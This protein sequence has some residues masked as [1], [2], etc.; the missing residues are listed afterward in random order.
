MAVLP[1]VH[2]EVLL[3]EESSLVLVPWMSHYHLPPA[4][5]RRLQDSEVEDYLLAHIGTL[6]HPT[7]G[8]ENLLL[9]HRKVPAPVSKDRLRFPPDLED[10]HH[11][12]KH[13]IIKNNWALVT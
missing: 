1:Q 3:A 4:L 9:N 5:P 2:L 7:I 8:R 11:I 10:R 13:I 12:R 6:C